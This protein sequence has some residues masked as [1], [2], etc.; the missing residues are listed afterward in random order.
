MAEL[1]WKNFGVAPSVLCQR[2][3]V[4]EFFVEET[5][6]AFGRLFDSTHL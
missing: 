3:V 4:L 5:V 1:F 6:S 2:N